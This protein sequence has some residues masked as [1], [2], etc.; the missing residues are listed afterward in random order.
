VTFLN[1]ELLLYISG[2]SQ[3]SLGDM[4]DIQQSE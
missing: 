4:S 1:K 2:A 3:P